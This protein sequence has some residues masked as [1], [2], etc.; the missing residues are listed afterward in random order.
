M[1][2]KAV[3]AAYPLYGTA[4]LAPAIGLGAALARTDGQWGAA[5]D[6]ALLTRLDLKLGDVVQI[7]EGAFAIRAVLTREP[8]FGSNLFVFG[9]RVMVSRDGLAAAGLLQ[10]GA[11]IGQSYRVRL[12][13][14]VALPEFLTGIGMQL[15]DAGWRVRDYTNATPSIERFLDRVTLFM[16]LVGLTALLVGGIGIGNAVAGYLQGKRRDRDIEVPRRAGSPRV[17]RSISC[18]SWSWRPAHRCSGSSSAG[19]RRSVLP[20]SSPT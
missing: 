7:G 4:E 10:P 2:L 9:P 16:T 17:S 12:A 20:G 1:E 19:L 8:D 18:R 6:A 15:P 14:D 5:V 3:D 13:P 11:F